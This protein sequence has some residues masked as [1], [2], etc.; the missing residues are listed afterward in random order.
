MG[1]KPGKEEQLDFL[2]YLRSGR[3]EMNLLEH[4]VSSANKNVDRETR[5]LEFT[6]DAS[7][8]ETG[9]PV[10]RIWKV[11]FSAEYG[12]PTPKDDDVFVA[13]MKVSQAQGLMDCPQAEP[14]AAPQVLFTSYEL[15]RILG[16][17]D[18]GKSYRAIDDALNRICGVRIVA[19]NY[20]YDNETKL[21]V[22]RKFGIVDD[23]Y[24]YE[25]AKYDRAKRRAKEV[26][27][28]N[29]QS[30]LRWSDVMLESFRS[31]YVR[32]LDIEVYRSIKNPI[33]R[34]LFRYLGKQFWVDGSG[35]A[36]RSKHKIDIREL[37]HEKLGYPKYDNNTCKQKLK[38]PLK[39]LEDA[40]IF[41]LRHEFEQ[42]YGECRI[43]FER[44]VARREQKP[45]PVSGLVAK[46]L[47]LRVRREDAEAAVAKH[48]PERI[49]EDIEDASFRERKGML[50]GTKAGCLASMLKASEPW[51]RPQGFVSSIERQ[52][53]KEAEHARR[54][55][56]R[57]EAKRKEAEE[58]ERTARM[59]REFKAFL[60]TLSDEER[61]SYADQAVSEYRIYFGRRI[62]E[63]KRA[64]EQD[65][66]QQLRHDAM[67][68][69]W[70]SQRARRH[71]E[72]KSASR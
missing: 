24:L 22:D 40:G 44:K 50:K 56:E 2:E 29:P 63:S 5:S 59:R 66:V 38:V 41:G 61:E 23:V 49:I 37:C 71:S 33:A 43:V 35:K 72:A 53:K 30:W 20:W 11:T 28:P 52:R 10:K 7:D 8:P 62:S 12:R 68:M 26:G 48:E 67:E 57:D 9:E 31:G 34:K 16:W 55:K 4:S 3:D 36:K 58:A 21:W 32:K 19:T 45:G 15:I 1:R 47:E 42:S 54:L 27:E 64:G 60:G 46:L 18:C 69:F 6:R 14:V 25:R 17:D 70:G 39:E 65:K 13:L 51:D